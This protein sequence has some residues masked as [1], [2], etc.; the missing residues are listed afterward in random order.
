MIFQ[1]IH[2]K[3]SDLTSSLHQ[4]ST[5]TRALAGFSFS[6]GGASKQ[7]PIA[8]V[9]ILHSNFQPATHL[10]RLGSSPNAETFQK[11]D[12][13]EN[14]TEQFCFTRIHRVAQCPNSSHHP[15]IGDSLSPTDTWYQVMFNIPN[16]WD[17]YPLVI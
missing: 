16:S 5:N 4:T 6:A 10:H 8:K 14:E 9:L 2:L 11:R 7:A 15:N 13:L 1:M 3:M 12:K 17:I